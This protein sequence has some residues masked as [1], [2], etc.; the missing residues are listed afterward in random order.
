MNLRESKTRLRLEIAS[1]LKTC[2]EIDRRNASAQVCSRLES[3]SLNGM[4]MAYLPIQDELDLSPY[5]QT[6]LTSGAAVPVVDW[7]SKTMHAGRL[8]GLEPPDVV[9]GKHGVRSPAENHPVPV[10]E[11]QAILVPGVAFDANCNRLGR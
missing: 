9:V 6:R 7:N 5:L 8:V 3:L 1:R 4:I 2:S 11:L 10:E